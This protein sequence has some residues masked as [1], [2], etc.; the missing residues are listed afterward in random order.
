MN[1]ILGRSV[2]VLC[3][4]VWF[5]HAQAQTDEIQVYDAAIAAPGTFSLDWHNNYLASAASTPAFAG[6][7]VP[8][9]AFNGVA[10]WAYGVTPWF[11]AGVYFPLYSVTSGNSLLYDGLKFRALFVT[12]DAANRSFFYGINAEFSFNTAHWN[13]RQLTSELRPIIGI[14]AGRFDLIFNPILD[15]D[16]TGVGNLEFMPATRIA[17]K[18]TG[19]AKIAIE[20][21]D[22]FG[23]V[24]HFLPGARQSHQLF[25]VL[26]QSTP[27]FD[28]EAGVGAGLNG[29]SDHRIVKLILMKDLGRPGGGQ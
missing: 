28:V 20:E 21:Y 23:H 9:H 3:S 17:M 15:S 6:G 8:D 19:T 5:A 18:V 16:Y 25:L 7:L 2:I 4:L 1:M 29:A 10:E 26:D 22:D 27:W 13:E 24:G 12:P 14:H 11:E